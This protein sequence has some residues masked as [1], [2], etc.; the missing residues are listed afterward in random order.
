MSDSRDQRV[1]LRLDVVEQ[2]RYSRGLYIAAMKHSG[3]LEVSKAELWAVLHR[4][5]YRTSCIC[6]IITPRGQPDFTACPFG[7]VHVFSKTRCS[8]LLFMKIDAP[9]GS[10]HQDAQHMCVPVNNK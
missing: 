1:F 2:L 7:L 8:I 10:N 6:S 3:N 9:T 5:C 4:Q